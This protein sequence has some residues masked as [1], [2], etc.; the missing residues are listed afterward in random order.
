MQVATAPAFRAAVALLPPTARLKVWGDPAVFATTTT[1]WPFDVWNATLGSV[2]G[3]LEAMRT[4]PGRTNF[5]K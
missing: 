1:V 5:A 2:S 4:D 3:P